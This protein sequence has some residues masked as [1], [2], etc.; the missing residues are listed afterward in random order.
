MILRQLTEH[1]KAQNWFAVAID[2]VIVVAGVFV[3]VQVSNWNDAAGERRRAALIVEALRQDL[4]DSI[5]VEERFIAEVGAGLAAFDAARERG[6]KPAP[7]TFRISGSDRAPNSI[8]QAATQ[9]SLA[10]LIHPGLLFDLGFYYSERDGIGDKYVR[11][12][13]F[14]E[15][16]ILPRLDARPSAF[17]DDAGALKPEFAANMERLRE[18]RSFLHATVNESKCLDERFAAPTKPGKSCRPDYSTP[19]SE[20]AP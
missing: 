13:T 8:W 16:E 14:V 9:S 7:Y 18:W 11:Y 1:V 17:Y 3:G 4:R 15:N 12:V 19:E 5:G 10:D 20:S 2:F 6:E